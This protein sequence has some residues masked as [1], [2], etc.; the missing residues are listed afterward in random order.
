MACKRIEED[1]TCIECWHNIPAG[2]NCLSQMPVNMP[3]RIHRRGYENF[4]IKCAECERKEKEAML[5][6]T[7]RPLVHPHGG[8]QGSCQLWLLW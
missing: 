4:C 2:S 3:D 8:N 7:P 5:R 6:A 1:L